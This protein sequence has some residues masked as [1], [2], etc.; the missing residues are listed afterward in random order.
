MNECPFFILILSAGMPANH[1]QILPHRTVVK[2]LSNQRV[3]IP[4]GFCKQQNA[5]SKPIDAM[6]DKRSLSPRFQFRGKQGPCGRCGRILHRHGWKS[7]RFI[8]GH[9]GIVFVEHDQ[10]PLLS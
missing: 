5:G 8:D 1:S 3:A 6:Y 4:F 7:G 9:D 10:P 2:K